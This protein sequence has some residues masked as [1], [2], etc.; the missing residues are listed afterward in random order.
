MQKAAL[1]DGTPRCLLLLAA[2]GGLQVGDEAAGAG[3]VDGRR[4]V[5]DVLGDGVLG[6]DGAS[7]DRVGLAGLGEGVV[8]AVKVLAL[9]EVLGKVIRLGWE[10]A[11]Q[12]E[13]PLF[14]R[15]EGLF[16]GEGGERVSFGFRFVLR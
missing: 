12:T 10:L 11:V 5:G 16:L 15:G 4:E 6:A 9:L 1:F 2:A 13:E 7:V 8:A 3:A 14:L